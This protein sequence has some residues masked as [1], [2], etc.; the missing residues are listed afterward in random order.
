MSMI[1][2]MFMCSMTTKNLCSK[3]SWKV[4]RSKE[5][6]YEKRKGFRPCH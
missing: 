1:P 6:I 3:S 2:Y 5:S 4:E